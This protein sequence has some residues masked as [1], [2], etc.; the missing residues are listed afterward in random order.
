MRNCPGKCT[1]DEKFDAAVRFDFRFVGIALG[2]QVWGVPVENVHVFGEN[3]D[4]L[5]QLV[6][7]ERVVRFGVL[8]RQA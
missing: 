1:A 6:P 2:L 3:V 4:M 5:E 7:H 8:A